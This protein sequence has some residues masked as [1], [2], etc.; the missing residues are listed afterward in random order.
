MDGGVTAVRGVAVVC[1]MILA[2]SG[3]W[4]ALLWADDNLA[5]QFLSETDPGYKALAAIQKS[6]CDTSNLVCSKSFEECVQNAKSFVGGLLFSFDPDDFRKHSEDFI[7]RMCRSR[8]TPFE[9]PGAHEELSRPLNSVMKAAQRLGYPM[10]QKPIYGMVPIPAV[11]AEVQVDPVGAAPIILVNYNFLQ[12]AMQFSSLV[13]KTIPWK[14]LE[15]GQAEVLVD[16]RAVQ[17]IISKQADLRLGLITLLK[18]VASGEPPFLTRNVDPMSRLFQIV[19]AQGIEEFALAHE[20]GHV[21]YSHPSSAFDLHVVL[22]RLFSSWKDAGNLAVSL[23]ETE[24]D[25][26]AAR[27]VN[28]IS[29]GLRSDDN[30]F[31]AAQLHAAEF[32]FIAKEII[33]EAELIRKGLSDIPDF[34]PA[35][36]IP[37][38]DPASNSDVKLL[39]ECA[40]QTD[41]RPRDL[42]KLTAEIRN[43]NTHPSPLFRAAVIRAIIQ[44][45]P[46][47]RADV[48]ALG[49]FMNRNALILWAMSVEDYIHSLSKNE[50]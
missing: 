13:A 5:T 42:S 19:Y 36:I 18:Q 3:M 11:G 28:N 20:L 50:R 10:S 16:G 49:D 37:D 26:F 43:G 22:D 1:S 44:R 15:D 21:Y 23:R 2:I 41:C 33:E 14:P 32:Y 7:P 38:F 46:L 12:F 8:A 24:A 31:F 9:R 25:I 48:S 29:K 30:P 4:S 39:A 47:Q 6:I 35:S 45:Q 40:L 17:E 34:D 27:I